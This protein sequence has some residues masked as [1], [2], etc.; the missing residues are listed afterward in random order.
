MVPFLKQLA[1]Y[2][3]QKLGN[4]ISDFI[5]VFPNRRSG[6]YFQ[7]YLAELVDKP[8]WSPTVI[9]TGNLFEQL[10]G[11]LSADPILL[12]HELYKIYN[13]KSG[14]AE[15]FDS[16]YQWGEILL[17]DF[18]DIDKYLVNA[19]DLFS[20]IASLREI[21]QVFDYLEEEQKEVIARFWKTVD[22]DKL[23]G[24]QKDFVKI[25]SVLAETYTQ[26]KAKLQT[27]GIAY[28]GMIYREVAEKARSGSLNYDP[29]KGFV[30]AG[31]NALNACEKVLFKELQRAGMADFIW[32]YDP[33]YVL[34]PVHEAGFFLRTNLSNFP[35]PEDWNLNAL[36][37]EQDKDITYM[38]VPSGVAQTKIL[39][40]LLSETEIP[41]SERHDETCIVL[42]DEHLLVPV[43][44]SLPEDIQSINVTM[45]YPLRNT[46]AYS[47]VDDLYRLVQN[48][49][50][51][52]GQLTYYYKDVLSVLN[53]PY[54][55]M[56]WAKEADSF[57]L[58]IVTF[59]KI[60]LSTADLET[61]TGLKAFFPDSVEVDK[62][63]DFS[64]RLLQI[65]FGELRKESGSHEHADNYSVE[66]I[67]S[68]QKALTRLNEL[69]TTTGMKLR[70]KT[71][72]LLLRKIAAGLSV[73][74]SGEPLKG[75][76]IMG[77]LESRSID[78]DNIVILSMNEGV[79]PMSGKS[80][81]FIP[82]N[83]R[84]GFG[85]PTTEHQDAIYAYYF[86]RL[87]Q[88]AKKLVFVYNTASGDVAPGEMSRYLYQ[89]KYEYNYNIKYR[90]LNYDIRIPARAEISIEKTASI[91]E[92]LNRYVTGNDS[93]S[94]AYLS[95]SALNTYLDC[96]LKFYF[97]YIAGI[98][99]E[100]Q[101]SEE[102]DPATF[103]SIL[104]HA[105]S[106]LYEPLQMRTAGKGEFS[107]LLNSRHIDSALQKAFNKY[108]FFTAETVKN[109]ITGRNSIVFNIIRK[110]IQQIIKVDSVLPDLMIMGLE[111]KARMKYSLLLNGKQ[112]DVLLGGTID[113]IDRIKSGIRILDYKT[114]S[115]SNSFESIEK[116]FEQDSNKR[117][118]SA[119]QVL[120]YCIMYLDANPTALQVEP[121]IYWVKNLF[122][123]DFDTSIYK[124]QGRSK[125]EKIVIHDELIK[126][127]KRN[128]NMLLQE[129]FNPEIPFVQ[130]QEVST[131]GYCPFADI[132]RR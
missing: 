5:F 51:V 119:F 33:A 109:E 130:T 22:F 99:E 54:C 103:G 86:Y 29:G 128:L 94:N 111:S 60:R 74:F 64:E 21:D 114:G 17:S 55:R 65:L 77:I 47:L 127:Y 73:S 61:Y 72:T 66:F 70:A 32:D 30:F 97:S 108:V 10:S 4:S 34:N 14:S 100:K 13:E 41:I 79:W 15:D 11:Y 42:S 23:T 71:Y 25:W 89:L 35:S 81:S 49:K 90:Y 19:N 56:L 126:E 129:L 105:V 50:E 102:I 46:P 59:N 85:L 122:G 45:G 31:F 44:S 36:Q 101:V 18:D 68:L 110:Y 120:L 124:K 67:W 76:Q 53:H 115:V 116:L 26:F 96:R 8:L 69:V 3:W 98:S 95:P 37:L 27:L 16:F 87:I 62:L 117:T 28:E 88:R 75:L 83:L 112:R 24:N 80:M 2:Y 63:M 20:N 92:R 93:E 57:A 78:F 131:C 58:D 132:C 91:L 107:A 121:G 82:Y 39:E 38:G 52:Q 1:I 6:L 123:K 12:N 104:H 125:P 106:L 118:T 48:A 40:T 7:H 113:R 84:K 9:T 43:L